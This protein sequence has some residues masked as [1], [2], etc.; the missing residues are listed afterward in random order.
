MVFP[1]NPLARWFDEYLHH[2]EQAMNLLPVRMP[3]MQW[4]F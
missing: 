1:S 4:L 3:R 2:D